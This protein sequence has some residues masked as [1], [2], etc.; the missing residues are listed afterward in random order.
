MKKLFGLV[1]E[2]FIEYRKGVNRLQQIVIL[3]RIQ[4]FYVGFARIEDYTVL[5][6][7]VP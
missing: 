3:A 4:L 7:V 1:V 2:V 6:I 5:K